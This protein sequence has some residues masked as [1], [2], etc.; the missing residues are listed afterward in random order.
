MGQS[1]LTWIHTFWTG[2]HRQPPHGS[3][4]HAL[5]NAACVLVLFGVAAGGAFWF[6]E[7]LLP[8]HAA[9]DAGAFWLQGQSAWAPDYGRCRQCGSVLTPRIDELSACRHCEVCN[10]SYRHNSLPPTLEEQER[11]WK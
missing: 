2:G 11:V 4:R 3:L 5:S 7:T 1:H 9:T 8:P 6:G 10:V